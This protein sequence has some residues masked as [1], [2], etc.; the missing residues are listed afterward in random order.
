[1]SSVLKRLPKSSRVAIIRLRSL[2][3]CVLATP[4]IHLLKAHRP[5]LKLSVVVE[6][7][8]VPLFEENPDIDDLI[9]PSASL[10]ER[11]RALQ[12]DR[13]IADAAPR[14]EPVG[15]GEIG[16]AHV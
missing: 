7:R 14:I 10:L 3:D 13:Q 8:F 9:M 15:R 6:P 11:D 4:A 5:D 1:M 2:G 12:L 16:R